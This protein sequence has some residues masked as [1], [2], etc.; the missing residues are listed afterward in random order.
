MSPQLMNAFESGDLRMQNWVGD[1]TIGTNTYYYPFKY[2]V[3]TSATLTEYSMVLRL[4]EQYLIRAEARANQNDLSEAA[5]DLNIIRNRAGLNDFAVTDQNTILR[6][7]QHER[8][9]ELFTEWGHRWMDLIRT[10]QATPVLS[11]IKTDWQATD[12]LY[13]I[14]QGEI[15]IDPHLTQNEGY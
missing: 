2:K 13:P 4:A 12:T 5:S 7:I 6:A 1:T 11:L 8:Q 14:P 3:K 15:Q 10:N 9:V